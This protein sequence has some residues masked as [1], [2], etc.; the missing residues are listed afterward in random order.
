MKKICTKC[1]VEKK[2]TD[3]PLTKVR[4]RLIRRSWCDVCMKEYYKAYRL[5]K[6]KREKTVKKGA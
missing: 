5:A 1:K 2:E 6:L 3:F 4:G